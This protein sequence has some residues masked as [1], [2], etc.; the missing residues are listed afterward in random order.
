MNS[1]TLKATGFDTWG[2]FKRTNAKALI[3]PRLLAAGIYVIR[4][5]PPFPR[6]VGAIVRTQ[7]NERTKTK[8]LV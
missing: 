6:S 5:Q 7:T 1:D 4:C 2:P 3:V 8:P